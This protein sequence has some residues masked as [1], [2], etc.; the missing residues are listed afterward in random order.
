DCPIG[1]IDVTALGLFSYFAGANK[2]IVERLLVDPLLTRLPPSDHGRYL[3]HTS[4][5]FRPGHISHDL[6]EGYVESIL[7]GASRIR[8]PAIAR[9]YDDV[10]LA[11]EAP[12]LAPGRFAA[13][14]RLNTGFDYGT[15][16]PWNMV[17]GQSP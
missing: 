6:P 5:L 16:A 2:H 12:L 4:F 14:W 17:R 3:H 7:P 13:I 15:D 9:L 1:G 11:T 8:D 10:R